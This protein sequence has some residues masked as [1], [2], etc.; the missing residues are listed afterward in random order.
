MLVLFSN[1]LLAQQNAISLASTVL[2]IPGAPSIRIR[3]GSSLVLG[4]GAKIYQ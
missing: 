1:V 3:V 2:P 4:S